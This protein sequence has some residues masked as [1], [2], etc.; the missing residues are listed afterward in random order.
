MIKIIGNKKWVVNLYRF[1]S[2]E[3]LIGDFEELE[4]QQIY[5]AAREQLNDPMEGTLRY[6][7][8]GDKIVWEN[9]LKHFLLCLE[10]VIILSRLM[11]DDETITK[12]DIPIFK[13]EKEMPSIYRA[14]IQKI[15]KQFFDDNFVK[16]YLGFILSNPNKI[17]LEEM[18][19]HL[20]ALSRFA[21]KAIFDED[22]QRGLIPNPENHQPKRQEIEK[23]LELDNIWIGLVNKADSYS[24]LMELI[25]NLLKSWD[26]E[27]LLRYKDSP[28]FQS[29]MIEFP[30]MYLD[31][32]VRLTYPESYVACFMDNCI[33]SSIWGTY[34]VNHTGVCL[35]FK[36]ND[37]SNAFLPLKT[38]IGYSTGTGHHYGYVNFPLKPMEYSSN[39]DEID[40]FRNIGRLPI[41]QLKEQW[42]T[43]EN[44]DLSICSENIFSKEE[45]WRKQYWEAYE[46]AYL[47]KLPAWSHEREFRIILSS[48]LGTYDTPKNRLLVY[49]FEDLEAIIFG[50]NTPKKARNEII[51]IVKR[52]CEELGRNQF[53][54]FEMAFSPSKNELYPRKLSFNLNSHNNN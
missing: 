18:Y 44:G 52:K 33:N 16:S 21:L 31:S 40:F 48:A 2:V 19:V 12:Q 53:D 26:S 27:L 13:N 37:P 8:Q 39:F 45:E 38:I 36:V 20:K 6:F 1:R 42:Y 14:R 32:V 10:H 51:E 22:I 30:Q 25:H 54:F 35:K 15:N 47:K 4:K 11:P 50:M 3:N 24:M 41:K 5:F 9:L 7:W 23:F 29:I 28:K 34:G 17:Y 43:N 46:P 49:R